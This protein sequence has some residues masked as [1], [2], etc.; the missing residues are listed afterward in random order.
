MRDKNLIIN[1]PCFFMLC[2]NKTE[3]EC[4]KLRLFGDKETRIPH[5]RAIKPG[6]IGFLINISTD[7]LI[8]IFIAESQV[9]LNIVPEAWSGKFPAQVKVKPIGKIQKIKNFSSSVDKFIKLIEIRKFKKIYKVP[10]NNVYGPE[11]TIKVLS[12]FQDIPEE[13]L[14]QKEIPEIGKYPNLTLD[15]VA[16]LKDIKDFIYQRIIAPFEDEDLAYKLKL[17]VGGGILLFGPPG[18][19]KTLIAMA[20]AKSIEAKFIEISP[21][22][23]L[24]YPGEAEKRL[25][26]IFLALEKEPRAVV[27]LDEAE[28]IL[29]KREEQ[30]STVMQRITPVLLAQL[31]KIFRERTKPIIVIAATNK[32]ELIDS[33]FLR[34]GRFD[35]IFYV[36]LPDKDARKE[37][38]KLQL[39]DR[40]NNIKDEEINQLAEA[41]E[42]YSGADI[43][44]IIEEAA[45]L[46]FKRKEYITLNDIIEAKNHTPK[47]V[48]DQELKR[49]EEWARVRGIIS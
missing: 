20:I 22:V 47:S 12:L 40:F 16:G 4:L 23:I 14:V 6:D 10:A 46:A 19:G 42:G 39:K 9:Q 11:I 36:G 49:L 37:I 43:E 44:Q 3:E 35:K 33:A 27:F 32:P 30:T 13:L 28:W 26:N 48:N 5:L 21:S 8:G 15:E 25:E 17:R 18:T 45:F 34:P 1:Q 31:S 38:L 24:G 2:T 41:L 29:N 7:E